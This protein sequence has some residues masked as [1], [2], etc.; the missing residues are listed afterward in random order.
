[1]RVYIAGPM[2]GYPQD[3]HPAFNRM[4]SMLVANG[5]KPINPARNFG[6]AQDLSRGEVMRLDISLVTHCEAIVFLPGWEHSS[7]ASTEHAVAAQLGL[8][9]LLFVESNS[10]FTDAGPM[11]PY[12][13]GA[14]A[15]AGG[16][17]PSVH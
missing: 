6:G 14:V 2:T 9:E 3:N 11:T 12:L 8:H 10:K 1:M 15:F 4:E 17:E 13:V 7:G 16:P 5:Y